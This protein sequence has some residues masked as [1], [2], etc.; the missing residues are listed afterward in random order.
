MG[1]ETKNNLVTLKFK[2]M[3]RQIKKI[4]LLIIAI[5]GVNSVNAQIDFS[6]HLGMLLP[7]GDY[8]LS[9]MNK[10]KVVWM[11]ETSR[12]GAGLG[13]DAGVKIRYGIPFVKGLGVFATADFFLNT[14]NKDVKNWKYDYIEENMGRERNVFS[15]FFSETYDRYFEIDDIDIS[16]GSYKNLPIMAGLNYE[17]ETKGNTKI[18][19]EGALG[20][21][22]SINA[23]DIVKIEESGIT[24][25]SYH[26]GRYQ[27]NEVGDPYSNYVYYRSIVKETSLAFQ[28]GAGVM[29][30]DRY[31]LGVHYYSL[32][33]QEYK[34]RNDAY[35]TEI[36]PQ[37]LTIRLGYH[38]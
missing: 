28:F 8:A 23:S 38:F 7:Q 29:F 33:T 25:R 26:N 3:K 20:V 19:I 9:N 22:F 4:A 37:M 35:S 5:L 12:A 15:T 18:W 30:K 10:G 16:I 14:P 17:Y 21:N 27:E 24:T 13:F 1:K 2:K 6:I 11:S 34:E 32:G 36:K 31:S